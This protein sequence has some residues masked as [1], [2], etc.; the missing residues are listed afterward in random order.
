MA[1]HH[2]GYRQVGLGVEAANWVVQVTED[3]NQSVIGCVDSQVVVDKEVVACRDRILALPQRVTI[4]NRRLDV[5]NI[6]S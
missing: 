4:S 6:P 3:C 5:F 1:F 2:V